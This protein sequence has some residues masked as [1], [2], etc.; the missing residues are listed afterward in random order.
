MSI[1]KQF[2]ISVSQFDKYNEL[3]SLKAGKVVLYEII[4]FL[5]TTIISFIPV[6]FIFI[7]YGGTGGIIDHFIP[8]FKIENG[9]LDAE[10]TVIDQGGA[11]IIIDGNNVR[12]DFDLQG[13]ENGVIFDREK[14]I[15]NSGIKREQMTYNELLGSLGM[16]KFEK[17]DIFNYVPQLNIMFLLFLIITFAALVFSEI[18]GIAIISLIASVI[19]IFL[20]KGLKYLELIKISVYARSLSAVLSAVLVLFGIGLGLIFVFILNAAYLFFSIK[21]YHNGNI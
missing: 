10:T 11:L 1:F 3:V 7:S 20:K 8:E 21:N 6:V 17:S 9:V 5:V 4:L 2:L 12:S 18:V 13:V 14:I 15:V 19:N 16:D